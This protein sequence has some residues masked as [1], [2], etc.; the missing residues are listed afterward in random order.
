MW[1]GKI[2][3]AGGWKGEEEGEEKGRESY[4][5]HNSCKI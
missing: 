2:R 4:F 5:L 1:I 3:E